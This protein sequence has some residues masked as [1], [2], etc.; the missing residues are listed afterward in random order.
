MTQWGWLGHLFLSVYT[1][2]CTSARSSL[3]LFVRLWDLV[4]LC[5]AVTDLYLE[6]GFSLSLEFWYIGYFFCIYHRYRKF[7][8]MF[9]STGTFDRL[10][11]KAT[12][13]LLLEPDW[14][15]T[16]AICDSVRGGDTPPKYAV[17]AIKKKFY[18]ENPHVQLYGLQVPYYS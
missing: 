18:H 4:E 11:E 15:S 2:H 13:Q 6:F 7:S 17:A 1:L 8:T 5:A 12:S 9:R 10:M 16:M 3:R 14:M